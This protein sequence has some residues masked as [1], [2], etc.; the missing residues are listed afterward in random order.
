MARRRMYH[1]PDGRL[2][3]YS[4]NEYEGD[5]GAGLILVAVVVGSLF[6][7]LSLA[8]HVGYLMALDALDWLA[9]FREH[10]FPQNVLAANLYVVVG[11]PVIA[12]KAAAG[13]MLEAPRYPNLNLVLAGIMAL[14]FIALPA[15]AFRR[16]PRLTIKVAHTLFIPAYAAAAVLLLEALV[17]VVTSI[18]G[19]LVS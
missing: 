8:A 10:E 17:W 14:A 1:T 6:L 16:E 13:W 19:W 18:G 4:K 7:L 2:K 15:Y 3:G 9:A 12:I 5:G 11:L